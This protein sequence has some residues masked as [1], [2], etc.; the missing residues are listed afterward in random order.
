MAGREWKETA[1]DDWDILWCEKEQI[2]WVYENNHLGPN[3]RV[4]HF[5]GYYELCR[6]DLLIKNLKKYRRALEKEGRS[7]E[8]AELSFVPMSYLLPSEYVI[9][10]DEFKKANAACDRS[11]WIMKPISKCQGRGIFLFTKISDVSQWKETKKYDHSSSSAEPY[12]VQRYIN[13]PLLLGGKKFDMRVYALCTSYNPLTVYLYRSGFA[14]F[15][16]ERYDF[17]NIS[18]LMCHLTNVAIQIKSSNYVKRIGGKWFIDKL[19]LY[20]SSKFGEA[21]TSEAFFLIQQAIIKSLQAVQK[22]V[23]HDKHCFELYGYDFLFDQALKPWLLEV[24]GGPSMTA[25]TPE[26]SAMKVNLLDDTFSVVNLEKVLKGDEEAVGGFELIV[27]KG[28]V[29]KFNH[30]H[31]MTYLGC[32]NIRTDKLKVLAKITAARLAK[33][34][35]EKELVSERTRPST[36]RDNWQIKKTTKSVHRPAPAKKKPAASLKEIAERQH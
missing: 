35:Q 11:I 4:N 36:R 23:S 25:N 2:D 3:Q 19:R 10:F 7:E 9:F 8:A 14:R 29:V 5:R 1:G 17:E 27:N 24:N 34:F 15:T 31:N 22:L 21:K 13:D 16:H 32:K 33:E 30:L 12:V 18:N 6:K 28:E 26:D 20:M